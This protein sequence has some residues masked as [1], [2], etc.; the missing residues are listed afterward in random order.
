[1]G[2]SALQERIAAQ[3][4]QLESLRQQHLA[5]AHERE[6][7]LGEV[8]RSKAELQAAH[9][10]LVTAQAQADRRAQEVRRGMRH[11]LHPPAL[12]C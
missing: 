10:Q 12:A 3:A 2:T 6:S 1:M 4:A 9:Q 8:A 5:A 7:A 11:A